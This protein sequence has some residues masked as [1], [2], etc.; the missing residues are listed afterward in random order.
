MMTHNEL[1]TEHNRLIDHFGRNVCGQEDGADFLSRVTY[2]HSR[3]IPFFLGTPWSYRLYSI[4]DAFKKQ[5]L[6]L[7]LFG[8]FLFYVEIG[9]SCVYEDI[10]P[11]NEFAYVGRI[12]AVA[13][14]VR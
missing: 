10:V 13:V 11:L 5:I 4:N 8:G 7:L 3:V 2:L 14:P 12:N 6:L 1:A 9:D